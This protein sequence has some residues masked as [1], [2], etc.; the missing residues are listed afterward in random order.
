MLDRRLLSCNSP[1]CIFYLFSCVS[2]DIFTST[3]VQVGKDGSVSGDNVPSDRS[4]SLA[5]STGGKGN[6]FT[7]KA[8]EKMTTASRRMKGATDSVLNAPGFEFV[9]E[10]DDVLEKD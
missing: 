5:P 3:G 9:P 8:T 10:S 7:R 2:R 1:S 6:N 4:S